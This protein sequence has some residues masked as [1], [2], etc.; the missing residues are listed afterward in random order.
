MH[1]TVG[2]YNNNEY[3]Y[4]I[5][6]DEDL[7]NH[8]EYNKTF[9]FGRALF[10]DGKCVNRGYLSDER[11]EEWTRRISEMRFDMSHPTIPYR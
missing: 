10:V 8:I 1:V 9:R 6:L 7:E 11:I 2:V 4:N 3:K 5:V